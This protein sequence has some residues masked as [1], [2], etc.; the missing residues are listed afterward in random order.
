MSDLERLKSIVLENGMEE[1]VHFLGHVS[2][3][4][5]PRWYNTCDVFAMPNRNIQGDNEGFGLVFL[6]AASSGKPALAGIDGGT[7]SAVV[8]G[9]TGLRVAGDSLDSVVEALYQI[10]SDREGARRMGETAR[11]RI[12]RNFT[13]KR[14]V[15]ELRKLA[16]DS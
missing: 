7:A 8:D 15:N 1:R 5:L 9:E 3:E 6:E 4:D 2:Y 10:L 12:L 11:Q 13:H 14:R 16:F